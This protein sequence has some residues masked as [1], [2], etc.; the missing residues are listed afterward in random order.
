MNDSDRYTDFIN[1]NTADYREEMRHM[2]TDFIEDIVNFSDRHF[3]DREQTMLEVSQS[4]RMIPS[5]ADMN[6]Y[7]P[8]PPETGHAIQR[9]FDKGDLPLLV[10]HIASWKSMM[11]RIKSKT[12]VTGQNANS[13]FF[14]PKTSTHAI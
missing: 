4:L 5:Y 13:V 14:M 12:I 2:I 1:R 8:V 11:P 9:D 6:K 3:V 10:I 7:R